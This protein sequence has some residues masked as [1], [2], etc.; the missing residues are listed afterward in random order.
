MGTPTHFHLD[1][2]R[3]PKFEKLHRLSKTILELL[4]KSNSKKDK[5]FLSDVICGSSYNL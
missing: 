5:R 3:W 2:S 4:Q 1:D